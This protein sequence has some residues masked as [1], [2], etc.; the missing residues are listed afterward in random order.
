MSKSTLKVQKNRRQSSVYTAIVLGSLGAWGLSA[1]VAAEINGDRGADRSLDRPT[2]LAL[3]AESLALDS[4]PIPL[5]QFDGA[6]EDASSD[7]P[8]EAITASEAITATEAPSLPNLHLGQPVPL[9][10]TP[11]LMNPRFGSEGIIIQG[12][13]PEILPSDP[14]LDPASNPV[15]THILRPLESNVIPMPMTLDNPTDSLGQLSSVTQL[16][17]VKPTDWAYQALKNLVERYNCIAGYPDGLFRG[18]RAITR[19]EAAAALNSCLD[20]L[21]DLIAAATDDIATQQDLAVL[22]RLTEDFQADLALL[23]GRVDGLENRIGYLE[24][25]QFS[26]T[27][28]LFGQAI[29]GAQMRSENTTNYNLLGVVPFSAEDQGTHANILGSADLTLFSQLSPKD[30]VLTTLHAGVGSTSPRQTNDVLL[31]FEGD[32]S[33]SGGESS[34]NLSEVSYRRLLSNRLAMIVGPAGVNMVNVFRGANAVE[35]SGYGPLSRFAQRNPIKNIGGGTAGLGLD[36]QATSRFSVQGV[37][38]ANSLA[39]DPSDGIWG[40]TNGGITSGLQVNW[41]PI[42]RLNLEMNYVYSYSPYGSLGTGVGDDPILVLDGNT[43][44]APMNTHAVGGTLSWQATNRLNVGGWAGYT[45]SASAATSGGVETINWMAFMNVADLLGEG[46]M[47]GL[48]VGQPPK[49]TSSDLPFSRNVPELETGDTNG[50]PSTTTHVEVFFRYR[51]NNHIAI[52]PGVIAVFN[53]R[54]NANNDTIII[55]AVRTTFSF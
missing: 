17:D 52:T 3:A 5:S 20:R 47:L 9:A 35:S 15:P 14:D 10:Q 53:P 28:R 2:T 36:W 48:Y 54:H 39:D 19:Y 12:P 29:M 7:D 18:S 49:I 31:A 41:A 22:Q 1:P 21:N 50:R 51:L 42:D 27:T 8:L 45:T 32:T 13:R 25:T 24:E 46:N 40:G 4:S 16:A 26:T 43:G 38:S 11:G 44:R 6:I 34:L 55:G 33:P 30:I 23:R 37:Y